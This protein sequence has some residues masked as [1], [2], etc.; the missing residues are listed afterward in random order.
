MRAKPHVYVAR[1][2]RG[3]WVVRLTGQHD[4]QLA[5]ELIGR[6]I[7]GILNAQFEVRDRLGRI[8]KHDSP[9]DAPDPRDVPG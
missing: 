1:N 2:W 8:R 4:S 3:K 6:S 5:A 9:G 7:A